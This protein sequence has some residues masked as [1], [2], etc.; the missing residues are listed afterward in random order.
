MLYA[1]PPKRRYGIACENLNARSCQLPEA[2]QRREHRPAL[3]ADL[4]WLGA[5]GEDFN[6]EVRFRDFYL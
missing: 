3:A 2:Q 5:M 1:S 4:E 6:C